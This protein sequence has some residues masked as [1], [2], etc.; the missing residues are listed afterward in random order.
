VLRIL[1]LKRSLQLALQLS[2][3]DHALRVRAE[4]R[5]FGEGREAEGT[6]ERRELNTYV[7]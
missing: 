1:L 6:A 3:V 7:F 2:P 5:V 4:T